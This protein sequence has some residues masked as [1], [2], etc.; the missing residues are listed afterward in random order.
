MGGDVAGMERV[1]GPDPVGDDP[2]R[3]PARTGGRDPGHAELAPTPFE[4]AVGGDQG[5]RLGPREGDQRAEQQR[6]P[7]A[8]GEVLVHGQ[9]EQ[10][11]RK[12]LGV[13]VREGA[14]P[15]AGEGEG[16]DGEHG[17]PGTGEPARQPGRRDEGQ[18]APVRATRSQSVGAAPPA[19]A[20]G[21]VIMTGSGFHEG[22][23]GTTV[24]SWRCRT[25]RPQT[26]QPQGS[27]V[28]AEGAS[29]DKA[30][31]TTHPTMRRAPIAPQYAP[32]M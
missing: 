15:A 16:D 20:S 4:Q 14:Q 23:P 25:S 30:A 3:G 1:A 10:P 6:A 24:E 28:G 9:D 11:D 12:R 32:T 2:E 13:A 26:I 8:T 7:G 21:V 17:R 29:S 19:R 31:R 5:E 18:S 22:A 27:V